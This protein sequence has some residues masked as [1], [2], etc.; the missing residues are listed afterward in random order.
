[1]WPTIDQKI[2]YQHPTLRSTSRDV[3]R[4]GLRL[5]TEAE[6]EGLVMV[7]VAGEV[8][9][10]TA[11]VLQDHLNE[12][13]QSRCTT[14]VI[15]LSKVGFLG[16]AGLRTL[17]AVHTEALTRG[18]ELRLAACSHPVRRA[19]AVTGVTH[20]FTAYPDLLDPVQ[21]TVGHQWPLTLRSSGV[22][23][24]FGDA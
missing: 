16:V 8:D 1:M 11:A 15:D 7:R 2:P 21:A 12:V 6:P 24:T 3:P 22:S 14:L 17:V 13:L 19:F 23:T 5:S 18:V 10:C 4:A 9:L 20:M